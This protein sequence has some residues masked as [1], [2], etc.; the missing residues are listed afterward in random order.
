[1]KSV[2]DF[3]KTTA[4]GG[5]VVI[6]PLTIFAIVLGTLINSLI[7]IT[8]KV[9][10]NLP[11]GPLGNTMVVVLVAVLEFVLLCFCTGLL[12]STR[13]GKALTEFFEYHI[14]QKIPLFGLLKNSTARFVGIR[15]TQFQPVEVDLY[16]ASTWVLGFIVEDLPDGRRECRHSVGGGIKNRFSEA[17]GTVQ[18][19]RLNTF[20]VLDQSH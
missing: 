12:P 20:V 14:A 8:S 10:G 16:G 17:C 13:P 5:L 11:F 9:A 7:A 3:I 15:G 19:E 2:I 4:I 1:M 18:P 6:I